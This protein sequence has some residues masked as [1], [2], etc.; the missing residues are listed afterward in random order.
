M[1]NLITKLLVFIFFTT[2]LSASVELS[3]TVNKYDNFT[4]KYLYDEHSS[5]T[6]NEIQNTN[7]EKTIPSQFTQGYRD[8]TAWFQID[9]GNKSNTE[10][11]I[12]Y[13][14][15]PIWSTF[16]LYKKEN[17]LW[18]IKK[19]GLNV[20]LKD[21]EI[22]D[23][24]PAFKISI[25]KG[26][27]RTFYFKG[28]TISG[29]IGEFQIFT[30]KEFYR[31]SRITI[32]EMY[33]IFSFMLCSLVLLNIYSFIITKERIYMF[34]IFYI[35][36]FI[37][38]S[39]MK[40]ASYMSFGL[41]GWSE[42]LH[43]IGAIVVFALLIFSKEFLK[44]NIYSK[45]INNAFKIFAIIFLIFS[46]LISI[47]IP[48]TSL[49]FNIVAFIFFILLLYVAI[50]IW[51]DGFIAAKYYLI[52]LIIFIPTMGIMTLNFNTILPNTDLTRY[53]FLAGALIEMLFFTL[54]LTN[55]YMDVNSEKIIIQN[56]LL[57]EKNSNEKKLISEIEKKTKHLT[58]ANERLTKQTDEL[59]EIKKQLTKEATTDM[60]S[61]L[62][63]RRYFFEASQKSFYAAMRYEQELSILMLDID[64]FKNLN[65]N[66]GHI[67]GDRVIRVLSNLLKKAVRTSD[68]LARYGG[69]EFIIL[70]PQSDIE[71]SM[72][73][74]ERIRLEIEKKQIQSDNGQTPEITVS[75]GLT[76][77]DDEKD[78]DIEQLILRC[79]KALY[80]AKESGRNKVCIL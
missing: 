62:Y 11:Y 32:T 63:N 8:G 23:N 27:S 73:F 57:E 7:F 2:A 1:R 72:Q 38:F 46:L 28:K 3:D 29:H 26:E 59:K 6:I 48:Y 9:L 41:K 21:R 35:T 16:D 17:S 52:A 75:I 47:N 55:R 14:T 61:G 20:L 30:E 12:I 80:S 5:L 66:F 76:Q 4:I 51:L 24:N 68:V 43:V 25:P 33:I 53:S 70:L 40:S 18:E 42:G 54:I 58:E 64:K 36:S 45:T 15:E 60:L 79:D 69:E 44:L 22:K 74:A 19:N 65:D 13:F 50:K 10:N 56:A 67:Y 31:P 77:L 71:K 34:Y 37:I 39:S 78:S 49:L